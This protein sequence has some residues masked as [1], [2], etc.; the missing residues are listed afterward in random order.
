MQRKMPLLT[1][2]KYAVVLKYII[3]EYNVSVENRDLYELFCRYRK[4]VKAYSSIVLVCIYMALNKMNNFIMTW[5]Y[6]AV[7]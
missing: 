5:Y 2:L 1:S 3:Y 7:L 4:T 6:V